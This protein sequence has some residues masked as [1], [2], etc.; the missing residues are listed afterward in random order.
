MY[1]VRFV[2][3]DGKPNEEYIYLEEKDAQYHFDCFEN[4]D[5]GL[6]IRIEIEEQQNENHVKEL[7]W[8][9]L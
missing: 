2:R 5:S 6:Y 3:K 9:Y 1:V 7:N 4:D 8:R